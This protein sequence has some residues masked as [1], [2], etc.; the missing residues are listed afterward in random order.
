MYTIIR[1]H[2]SVDRSEPDLIAEE[3]KQQHGERLLFRLSNLLEQGVLGSYDL[4]DWAVEETEESYIY[5]MTAYGYLTQ[6]GLPVAIY[7]GK[8][9]LFEN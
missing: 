1:E 8:D 4:R 5:T 3:N 2:F 7:A 9:I 6:K